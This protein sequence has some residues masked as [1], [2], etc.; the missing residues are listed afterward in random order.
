MTLGGVLAAAGRA[1]Q[2]GWF[3][4]A[5]SV[6]V[7][8]L[9]LAAFT[10]YAVLVMSGRI[11][12][13]VE[14]NF[15]PVFLQSEAGR[16]VAASLRNDAGV[17]GAGVG[18]ALGLGLFLAVIWLGAGLTFLGLNAVGLV[19]ALGLSLIDP[20]WGLSRL[21]IGASLL[22]QGFVVG[23][24]GV[25]AA[26]SG[27]TPVTAVARNVLNEA[28]RM[29][30]SLVFIVV[31]VI[32][33]ASLPSLL[34]PEKPL[35]YRVQTFLSWGTGTSFWVLAVLTLLFGCAT[36]TF[37]QRDKVIWQTMTK[38]V[39]AWQ[40][41][42]GKWLGLAGLNLVLLLICSGGVFLFVE[43]LRGTPA[44][45]ERAAFV[46]DGGLAISEDRLLLQTQVLVARDSE[47]VEYPPG[48]DPRSAEF[49]AYVQENIER[50]RVSRPDAFETAADRAALE[51]ELQT[52]IREDFRSIPPGEYRE[53][54]FTGLSRARENDLPVTFKY[55]IDSSGNRPDVFYTV[56]F[57]FP[58]TNE[59][60]QVRESALGAFQSIPVPV[61][62]IAEDGTAF[63]VV[64][65]GRPFLL[66]TGAAAIEPNPLTIRF[67]NDGLQFT[68][69]V[70][71]YQLN[72]LRAV[73]VLWI[74]LALV[75]MIAVTAGTFLSFPVAALVSVAAFLL[76]EMA[77]WVADAADMYGYT[78]L[79]NNWSLFRTIGTTV[80]QGVS[81]VFKVYADLNPISRVVEGLYL[82]WSSVGVGTLA[83][84]G[85]S[86]GLFVLGVMIFS[87]RELATYSGQ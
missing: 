27:H 53:Y 29:K 85:M 38:P 64:Y 73:F 55:K 67:P 60:P 23:I 35:R 84:V 79:D 19:A 80:A 17:I 87:K 6:V 22:S 37:E 52:N 45:G 61:S 72:Y 10:V 4:V 24:Q 78:D 58:L 2:T 41:V 76:A 21:V 15:D 13:G 48:F 83:L 36:V 26:F 31:L 11:G 51:R 8:V 65:N 32:A 12:S 57:W 44:Q 14:A 1:Q 25:R 28:V 47:L 75:A 43:Y 30:I 34:D 77:G 50:A 46:A 70:G 56:A 16:A 7:G 81:S 82:S 63:V 68:Y 18:A 33:L 5:A 54:R 39:A 49:A 9:V 69:S 59:P 71:S 74:K 40:Y 42:L 62:A 20:T 3:K 86:V 66:P